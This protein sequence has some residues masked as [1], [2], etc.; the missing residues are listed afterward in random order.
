MV[1]G[2]VFRL[3]NCVIVLC[4]LRSVVKFVGFREC[5]LK[6]FAISLLVVTV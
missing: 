3:G 5:M 1:I 2:V 4:F 6:E